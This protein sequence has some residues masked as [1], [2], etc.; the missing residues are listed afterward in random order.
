MTRMTCKMLLSSLV[1]CLISSVCMAAEPDVTFASL[2][3]EMTDRTAVA[4]WPQ[5]NYRSLQASSYNRK[6]VAPDQEGWFE[7][8]DCGFDYGKEMIDGR[9]ES[10][11]MKCDGPG[12]I[13]RIWTPAF[14]GKFGNSKGPTIRIYLDGVTE[15]AI[16]ADFIQLVT[17]KWNVKPPFAQPTVRAGD[18]Y[19]PIPFSKGCKVTIDNRA[20]FYIINY[21]SYDPGTTVETFTM[22]HLSKHEQLLKEIGNTLQNPSDPPVGKPLTLQAKLPA[23]ESKELPL[24]PGSAAIN[25]LEF[26]LS[27]TNLAQA[28]RSTVLEMEFDGKQ[29]VWCPLGDF[30]ANVNEIDPYKMWEREVK[31]DGTMICRWLMPYRE[32]GT[33]RLKNLGKQ[34]VD[35]SLKA[36]CMPWTWDKDSMYFHANWWTD[37]PYPSR[38]VTDLT[39]IDV[40]GRG[41]HVGDNLVVLNPDWYWWGEGDE[42][43]FVDEDFKRNFPSQFGTGSEDYYG[44]AGG[45]VPTREDEFSIPFLANVRVGGQRHPNGKVNTRGFNICTRTRALDATP[46]K[47]RLLFNMENFN[48]SS[49]PEHYLQYALIVFWYGDA[50]VT[51]NRPPMPELAAMDVPSPESVEAFIKNEKVRFKDDVWRMKGAIECERIDNIELNRYEKPQFK[52]F[53]DKVGFSNGTIV[54]GEGPRVRVGETAVFTLKEQYEAKTI[55]LYPAQAPNYGILNFYVN[56][57][58]VVEKWDGYNPEMRRSP[59]PLELGKHEPDGN[60]FRIKIEIVGKNEASKQAYWGMD[61]LTLE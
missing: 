60:V 43:I 14:Y 28:M 13:T 32:K 52:R 11:L 51:H 39:F 25:H 41:K 50:G 15:P 9:R 6:S 46:F 44:W 35:V 18:V 36:S 37:K 17:G 20:F 34:V 24:V 7:N 16:T 56:D 8:G 23:G 10:V 57:K 30:F 2:L 27:A 38:P 45:R 26:K 4:K 40:K 19:L 58:L 47:E 59:K 33:V 12:V 1:C 48:L 31:K 3:K 49:N 55:K 61:C 29:T 53:E 5:H 22:D 42:K 21:R 54:Y